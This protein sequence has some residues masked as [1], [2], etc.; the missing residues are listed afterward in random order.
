MNIKIW[1]FRLTPSISIRINRRSIAFKISRYNFWK[2]NF[3]EILLVFL[4]QINITNRWWILLQS[5]NMRNFSSEIENESASI[6]FI[7]TS[8]GVTTKENRSRQ[9]LIRSLNKSNIVFYIDKL[10]N[11]LPETEVTAKG[12]DK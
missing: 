11:Y 1:V 3:G 8:H 6:W 9:D 10:L 12:D 7:W 5:K 4:N 2:L